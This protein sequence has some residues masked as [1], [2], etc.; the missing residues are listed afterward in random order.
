MRIVQIVYLQVEESHP[1]VQLFG[2]NAVMSILYTRRQIS[3]QFNATKGLLLSELARRT[4]CSVFCRLTGG[5]YV[6]THRPE[7]Q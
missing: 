2:A 1:V 7:V 6:P 3:E 4:R 5:S